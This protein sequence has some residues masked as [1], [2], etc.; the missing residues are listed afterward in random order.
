FAET[1]YNPQEERMRIVLRSEER[2]TA[3]SKQRIIE[4]TQ[5]AAQE[6]FPEARAT[7]LFVLLTY[8][9]DSLLRDQLVSFSI[10]GSALLGMIWLAFGR[11]WFA[12][13]ALLPN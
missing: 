8:L 2:Q 4:S 11:I 6:I 13:V 12:I 5:A 10:A 1:L 7:G 3:D 9:I